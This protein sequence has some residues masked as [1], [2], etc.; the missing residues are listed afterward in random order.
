MG[1]SSEQ[2]YGQDMSYVTVATC[3]PLGGV[4]QREDRGRQG[5]DPMVA[6][7]VDPSF[8]VH[9]I[10]SSYYHTFILSGNSVDAPYSDTI[11]SL[12]S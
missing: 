4:S 11:I 2:A 5:A 9:L 6:E 7:S 8:P 10:P 12:H 3:S 1:A